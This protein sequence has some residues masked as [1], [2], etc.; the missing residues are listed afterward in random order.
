MAKISLNLPDELDQTIREYAKAN[1]FTLTNALIMLLKKALE[2]K[3]L[4]LEEVD[5]LKEEIKKL[6]TQKKELEEKLE[7]EKK[8]RLNDYKN[9]ITQNIETNKSLMDLMKADRVLQLEQ[10]KKEK[11]KKPFFQKLKALFSNNTEK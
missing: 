9:L 10:K 3:D 2:A 7:I 5:S 6:E 4:E 11:P 1:D 8:E